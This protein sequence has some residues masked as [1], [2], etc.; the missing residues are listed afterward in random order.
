VSASLQ[1]DD[2]ESPVTV[3]A[4]VVVP[5]PF[6]AVTPTRRVAATSAPTTT[7][8]FVV[9]PARETHDW[10]WALQR[11]HLYENVIG[12]DPDHAPSFAV[13]VCPSAAVPPI[14]GGDVLDGGTSAAPTTEDAAEGA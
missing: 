8:V 11:C 10:P 1:N 3:L 14:V 5:A 6:A 13:R 2:G 9:A 7:Y 4:Y 12:V